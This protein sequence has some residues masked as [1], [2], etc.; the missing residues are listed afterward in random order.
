EAA[1]GRHRKWTLGA[2]MFVVL[3]IMARGRFLRGTPFDPFGWSAHRRL[4]RRLIGEY[5]ARVEEL[6]AGLSPE[7]S[8]L[9]VEIARIPELVRGFDTVKEEHLEHARAKEAE[10]LAAFRLRVPKG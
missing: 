3:R 4:E 7:S 10:L 8:E 9:A 2:W 1:T 6:L 5:E